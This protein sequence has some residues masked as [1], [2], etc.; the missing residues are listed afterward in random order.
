MKSNYLT[1]LCSLI[2]PFAQAQSVTVRDKT[3]LQ[4]IENVEI[5]S[6]STVSEILFAKHT[7]YGTLIENRPD[8][9]S[10]VNPNKHLAL[11]VIVAD[12]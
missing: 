11:L 1:I 2:F 5:R 12:P 7:Y 3:S 10:L 4:P 8:D 9:S 6:V